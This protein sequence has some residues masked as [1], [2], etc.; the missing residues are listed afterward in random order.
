[1][2]KLLVF[3]III[4]MGTKAFEIRK[5]DMSKGLIEY[6]MGD[7]NILQIRKNLTYGI[8]LTILGE[9]EESL[10]RINDTCE[11][12]NKT[13]THLDKKIREI[14]KI[15]K[16]MESTNEVNDL[17]TTKS[18]T[19]IN[20]IE[21]KLKQFLNDEINENQCGIIRTMTD[22][23]S[24]LAIEIGKLDRKEFNMLNNI[25][26]LS[27]VRTDV[28]EML[29]TN[30]WTEFKFPFD[31]SRNFHDDF[32]DNT[33]IDIKYNKEVIYLT[34]G[35]PMYETFN[36]FWVF[37]KPLEINGSWNML[38][39]HWESI[40]KKE[41][42]LILYTSATVNEFCFEYN[43]NKFCS[44]PTYD[45]NCDLEYLEYEDVMKMNEKCFSAFPKENSAIQVYNDIYFNV[46]KPMAITINCGDGDYPIYLEYST[47][48]GNLTS[49]SVI[50]S[51]FE[52]DA[53]YNEFPYKLYVSRQFLEG[54]PTE[55]KM[56]KLFTMHN[57]IIIGII[58]GC[59]IITCKVLPILREKR[60]TKND[61]TFY[62]NAKD[63]E[64]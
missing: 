59:I 37:P 33:N 60:D 17:I 55:N 9:I 20:I 4:S 12:E 25:I 11:K 34:F 14:R 3:A 46:L 38:K 50:T 49:C 57:I 42:Q 31:F 30:L 48:I 8:D 53:K 21:Q 54:L 1:M 29:K 10:S 56:F 15:E 23:I 58:I 22:L 64:V 39:T 52:F 19:Y 6:P 51:F 40:A 62:V 61:I 47:H 45:N 36:E 2:D 28:M 18:F 24:K 5:D 27:E 26:P 35:I 7:V 43:S 44:I 32:L 41:Q 13:I 16:K 63:T